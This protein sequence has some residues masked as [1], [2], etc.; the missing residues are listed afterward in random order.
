MHNAFS[1]W[2]AA[3]A[4]TVGAM[5]AMAQ[6]GKATPLNFNQDSVIPRDV[7]VTDKNGSQVSLRALL[8]AQPG[9]VNVVF[10]FGGGDLGHNDPGHL[11]CPDSFEDTHILRTLIGKYTGKPVGFVAIA[12]APVYHSNALDSKARVFLD[13]ADDSADFKAARQSFITSTLAARDAGILP[14]EPYY[15]FRLHLMLNT[16]GRM[17]PGAGYGAM[18]P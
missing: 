12:S 1:R 3:C 18:Q 17:Q 4:L 11:W 16:T 5:S 7:S 13:D 9:N 2:L 10:I 8:E 14:I 6:G 15:D